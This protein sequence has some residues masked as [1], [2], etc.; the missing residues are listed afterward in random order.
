ME[1]DS[2]NEAMRLL[3]SDWI[4]GYLP[5]GKIAIKERKGS[6]KT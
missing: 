3:N 5:H 4:A 1:Q 6:I 2:D